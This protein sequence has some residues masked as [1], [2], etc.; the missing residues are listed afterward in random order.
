M[1]KFGYSRNF[2]SCKLDDKENKGIAEK[3]NPVKTDKSSQASRI[4]VFRSR[5]VS[6]A[7]STVQVKQQPIEDID[8]DKNCFLLSGI[9]KD[10]HNYLFELEVCV[11]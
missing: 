5:L 6:L 7:P 3:L 1:Q 9:A 10:I 2:T 11:N 4:P 8:T